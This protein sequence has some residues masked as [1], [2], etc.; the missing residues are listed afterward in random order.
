[1]YIVSNKFLVNTFIRL[2]LFLNDTRYV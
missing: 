1:V 2:W